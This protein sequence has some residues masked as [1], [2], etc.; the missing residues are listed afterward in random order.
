MATRTIV[1]VHGLFMTPLIWE[2]WQRRCSALGYRCLAP[3]WPHRDRTVA[4]LRAAHPDP[5]LGRLT[6]DDVVTRIAA[7]IGEL[8]EKP[9]VVGHSTGGLVAQILVG[10]NSVAAGAALHSAPPRG[11]FAAQASYLRRRWS[12]GG[13]LA[14]AHA[15]KA[16][17]F[18]EFR[19]DFANTL[20]LDAQRAAFD[21]HVVPES[22]RVARNARSASG[23]IDFA[24]PHAP[25][26]LTA[27]VEDRVFPASLNFNNFSKY[28]QRGATTEFRAFDGRDHFVF[29]EPGWEEV[30]DFVVDWL[31]KHDR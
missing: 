27:G 7:V 17:T 21:R 9:F 28:R 23:Q 18:D 19:R 30:A 14:G 5:E 8:G 15:P 29:A 11:V 6:L 4:E 2:P 16:L 13:L 10:R 26:L 12:M 24:G 22:R 1:F 3:A 25:L 31:E 20:A